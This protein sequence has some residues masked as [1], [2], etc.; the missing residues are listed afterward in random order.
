M[1]FFRGSKKT[2][3]NTSSEEAQ[4]LRP[5]LPQPPE[6]DEFG[7]RSLDDQRQYLLSLIEPLPAFGMYLLDAWGMPI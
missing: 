1:A 3:Q 6:A 4:E 2:E 5:S 7:R